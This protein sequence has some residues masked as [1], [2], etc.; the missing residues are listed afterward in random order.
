MSGV[1]V[2]RASYRYEDLRSRFFEIMDA[3][4]GG[5]LI[6]PG[7]DVLIKPNLLSPAKPD[8]AVLTHPL[9]VR[10]AAEY[11]LQRGGR[12]R[13]GDSP[14]VGSCRRVVR[15]SGIAGAL[16]DLDV[17][18]CEFTRSV[19]ADVGEPFGR[20]DLA[21]EALEA[22]VM[23]NLPKLKTHAQMGLTLGVKNLF[24]CVV[25]LRKAQW[26]LR[27]GID[28]D[29]FARLLVQ[30][31][32]CINP[33]FT[34]IDG[35]LA[36]EGEGPGRRGVPRELGLL[37]GSR[38]ALAA[39][40]TVCRILGQSPERLPVPKVA[41]QMGLC[42]GELDID[43]EGPLPAVS[44]FR[45]PAL[46]RLT[47]GPELLQGFIRRHLLQRPV[48]DAPLCTQCGKCWEMCPAGA[49]KPLEKTLRFDYDRC[50]RCYCCVEVCPQGALHTAESL[51]GRFV[52]RFVIGDA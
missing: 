9:V 48:C 15:E 7:R 40:R 16:S 33:A 38:D 49:I 14:G 24:G 27:A 25:G 23:I 45:L 5:A 47:Y 52:R 34:V 44:G 8:Q 50:I 1:V 30:I 20:I 35:I 51:A 11:V 46:T 42:G 41:G 29:L 21:A 39:D 17:E 12:P 3:L 18:F 22:P 32:R 4:D 31:Y 43:C 37:L 10:A 2:R 13:V 28:R 36:M 19:K 6:G 26:H